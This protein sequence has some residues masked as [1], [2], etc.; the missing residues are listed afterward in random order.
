MADKIINNYCQIVKDDDLVVFVG[1]LT[2]K[3]NSKDKGWLSEIFK[4][5]PGQKHL[6]VGNHDYYSKKYYMENCNFLSVNR[7]IS[8]PDLAISHSPTDFKDQDILTNKILIHGHV[9][10]YF[11][12]LKFDDLQGLNGEYTYDVG[13]DA[14]NF[15]PVSLPYIKNFFKIGYERLTKEQGRH[16][17]DL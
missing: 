11:P 14:N 17:R 5:L 4:N 15:A 7:Y 2:I 8:T 10:S 13:V 12:C 6:I 3:R 16:W 1:D 9:H